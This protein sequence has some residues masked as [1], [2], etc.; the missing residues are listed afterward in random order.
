MPKALEQPNGL[1]A[2]LCTVSITSTLVMRMDKLFKRC[3]S[4]FTF[5]KT[6]TSLISVGFLSPKVEF[7]DVRLFYRNAHRPVPNCNRPF[8]GGLIFGIQ[9]VTKTNS[10]TLRHSLRNG[11]RHPE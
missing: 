3:H 4:V 1:N 2:M 8:P 11:S 9:K 6:Y 5:S 10:L 7:G